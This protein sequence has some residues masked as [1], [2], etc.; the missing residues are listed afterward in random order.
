MPDP[1][2]MPQ[3]LRKAIG[4]A[5]LLAYVTAYIVAAL[6]VSERILDSATPWWAELLFFAIAGTAWVLPLKPLFSWMN[7]S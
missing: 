5:A 2:E 7:R 4:A 6:S 3:P 1:I